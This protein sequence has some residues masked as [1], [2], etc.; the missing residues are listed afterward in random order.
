[1]WFMQLYR[2]CCIVIQLC[3]NQLMTLMYI[4]CI[5]QEYETLVVNHH[6]LRH[7]VLQRSI[8]SQC[9][10]NIPVSFK[11]TEEVIHKLS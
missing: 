2:G 9:K 8:R 6:Y 10:V 7:Y 1:M 4:G 5:F 11:L 3:P